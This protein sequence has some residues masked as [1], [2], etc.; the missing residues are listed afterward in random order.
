MRRHVNLNGDG[1][2]VVWV[3]LNIRDEVCIACDGA[4]V[5]VPSGFTKELFNAIRYVAGIKTK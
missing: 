5:Q 2:K 4:E 3:Y 1:G